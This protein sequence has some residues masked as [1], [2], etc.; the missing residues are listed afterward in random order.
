MLIAILF[1][2]FGCLL[3]FFS[4]PSLDLFPFGL[5]VFFSIL[6]GFLS[7]YF[8]CV[9]C[10]FLVYGHREVQRYPSICIAVDFKL[11]GIQVQAR[12]ESTTFRLPPPLFMFSKSSFIFLF[13][14]S[15]IYR[16][17]S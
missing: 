14:V 15:P 10:M 2:A 12:S 3:L 16:S 6:I 5:L 7:L 11:T 13:C 1:I 9:L 8:L 4:A 17:Y